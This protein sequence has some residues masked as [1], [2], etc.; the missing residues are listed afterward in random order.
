VLGI[1][2]GHAA[3]FACLIGR[4]DAALDASH[5][6]RGRRAASAWKA[7]PSGQP[8]TVGSVPVRATADLRGREPVGRRRDR[9]RQRVL[10]LGPLHEL[11]ARGR[12][13]AQPQDP[14]VVHAA[15]RPGPRAATWAGG[16]VAVA[17]R[18]WLSVVQRGRGDV[19][20]AMA[21]C[22]FTLERRDDRA[23]PDAACIRWSGASDPEWSGHVV[24]TGDHARVA[25]RRSRGRAR[26]RRLP[27][28]R[29]RAWI[30]ARRAGRRERTARAAGRSSLTSLVQGRPG[31]CDRPTEERLP[32]TA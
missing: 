6:P 20:E 17:P 7:G 2:A 4:N 28:A 25:S 26:M 32:S 11:S 1:G 22:L 29:H 10:R 30:A 24:R 23:I 15:T 27:E 21:R 5:G 8:R 19:A 9:H 31:R 18:S 16:R 3:K 12:P 14:V 13:L